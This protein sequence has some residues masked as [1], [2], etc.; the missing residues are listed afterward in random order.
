LFTPDE[1]I[2]RFDSGQ[3]AIPDSLSVILA[4]RID[5]FLQPHVDYGRDVGGR[6][7]RFGFH[8]SAA[9]HERH[10]VPG[11]FEQV[12]GGD[13]C[14]PGADDKHVDGDVFF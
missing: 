5:K 10:G 8:A 14:N 9:L 11:A 13:P 2:D 3:A 12:C 6:V 7:S 4:E 1:P